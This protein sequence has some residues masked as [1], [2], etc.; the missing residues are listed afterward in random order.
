MTGGR[1]SVMSAIRRSLKRDG[2]GAAPPETEDRLSRHPR[3]LVPERANLPAVERVALFETMA[4]ELAAS[5]VSVPGPEAVPDAVAD[6]LKAENLPARLRMA[7]DPEVRD[8]PWEKQPLLEITEGPAREPDPVSLTASFAGVAETGTLVLH[9]GPCGP[10]S[11]NFL[12][13]THIVVLYADRVVGGYEDAW[14]LLRER[15]GAGIMPRT[16]NFISGPSRSGDIEQTIQLGAHGPR[17]L[18]II[19]VGSASD[20]SA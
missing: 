5:V 1:D 16:V 7:P 14:D 10:S 20:S 12:P 18:H 6:Y 15:F 17:R 9:S 13:E 3:H 4:R 11:L 8:L 2:K 19:L